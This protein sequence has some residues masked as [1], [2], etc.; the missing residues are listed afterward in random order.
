MTNGSLSPI[1]LVLVPFLPECASK[2]HLTLRRGR[3]QS[4]SK[5]P[6]RAG[7]F[8]PLGRDPLLASHWRSMRGTNGTRLDSLAD[9]RDDAELESGIS[10]TRA[11]R[12]AFGSIGTFWN[13]WMRCQAVRLTERAEISRLTF[14]LEVE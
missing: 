5:E 8:R 10:G 1:A 11:S 9:R 4:Y 6:A 7:A 12:R 13:L 3:P 14:F 2:R